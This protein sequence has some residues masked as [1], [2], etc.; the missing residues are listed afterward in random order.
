MISRKIN[1][2]FCKITNIISR[3]K[4]F[5]VQ[6]IFFVKSFYKLSWFHKYFFV[7]TK[8]KNNQP[9]IYSKSRPHRVMITAP[10]MWNLLTQLSTLVGPPIW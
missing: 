10:V 3:K 5:Y 6:R 9:I 1:I 8:V 7:N 2:N 4:V